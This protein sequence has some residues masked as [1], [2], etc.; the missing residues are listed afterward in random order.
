[1]SDFKDHPS[2]QIIGEKNDRQSSFNFIPVEEHYIKELL[3]KMNP[4]KAVS[5]DNISQRLLLLSAP[6]LTQPLT[7]LINHFITEHIWPSVWKSSNILPIFKKLDE[8]D[9]TNY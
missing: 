5:C 1:M 3:G 9:K 7:R 8:T 4:C 6:T 2:V